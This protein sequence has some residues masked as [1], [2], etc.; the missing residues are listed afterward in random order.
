MEKRHNVN[1]LCLG[2]EGLCE[3]VE[4]KT[5]VK[6]WL[7]LEILFMVKFFINCLYLKK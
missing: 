7:K 6:L 4:D 3:I 1:L 2:N 5:I